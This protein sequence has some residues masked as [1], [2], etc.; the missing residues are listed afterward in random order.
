MAQNTMGDL[1]NH[2]FEVIERLKANDDPEASDNEKIKLED[3]K[4]ICDV[5]EIIVQSAKVEVNYLN[6]LIKAESKG[7]V[8]K[9]Q[10]KML[11]E[12]TLE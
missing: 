4:C 2:L 7:I 3:A 1:Q 10:S 5:A 12:T 11:P 9:T 6:S 8:I